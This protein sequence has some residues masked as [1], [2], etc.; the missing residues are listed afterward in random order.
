MLKE[1]L[2]RRD[3]SAKGLRQKKSDD[4]IGMLK[5]E[6][7]LVMDQ[8]D[9]D[10][11]IQSECSMCEILLGKS[12]RGWGWIWTEERKWYTD[13]LRFIEAILSNKVKELYRKSRDCF[14]SSSRV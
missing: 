13:R 9:I 11:I 4:M 2:L 3:S 7:F 14:T 10:Y 6:A 5:P 8:S 12:E 1:E